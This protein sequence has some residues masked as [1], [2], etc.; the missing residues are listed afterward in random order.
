MPP[1]S[2]ARS[3]QLSA[4]ITARPFYERL[5][6]ETIEFEERVDDGSTWLM[7]QGVCRG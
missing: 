7:Q 1:A 5:G 2:A 6:Y 3:L 4:S